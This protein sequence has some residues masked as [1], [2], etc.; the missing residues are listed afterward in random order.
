VQR[1]LATTLGALAFDAGSLSRVRAFEIAT[2][3][4]AS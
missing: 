4:G 2:H 3:G 1:A